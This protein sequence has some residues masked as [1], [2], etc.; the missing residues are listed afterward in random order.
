[1][2]IHDRTVPPPE[3][4]TTLADHARQRFCAQVS[5]LL[6]KITQALRD[7]LNAQ[8]EQIRAVREFQ[9]ARDTLTQISQVESAWAERVKASLI[10]ALRPVRQSPPPSSS[11]PQFEQS[12]PGFELMA[13]EAMEDQLLASKLALSIQDSAGQEWT[14]LKVRLLFA[15]GKTEMSANDVVRPETVARAVVDAWMGV[16]LT[17]DQWRMLAGPIHTA[18]SKGMA[19]TYRQTNLWL[20]AKGVMAKIKQQ[21]VVRKAVSSAPST[22]GAGTGGSTRGGSLAGSIQ[23]GLGN[24]THSVQ[25][26]AFPS[27][28]SLHSTQLPGRAGS[29]SSPGAEW[30]G[31]ARQQTQEVVGHIL[32]LLGDLTTTTTASGSQQP[33]AATPPPGPVVPS[34]ASVQPPLP[35][36]AVP[37]QP[38][39]SSSPQLQALL[40]ARQQAQYAPTVLAEDRA[41]IASPQGIEQAT[42]QLREQT[43][44]FKQAA[45]T[46]GEK[47]T[48]EIV[49]LMFQSILS[50][51]RLQ[52]SLRVWFA[53]LQIPV[54]RVALAEPDFFSSLQHPAR[55][56]IDRMGSCALGFGADLN[57]V[58]GKGLETE[59]GRIV[60]V[61][62]Q[63]PETGRKVFQL[64]L[65]EFQAFLAR[66]LQ[67]DDQTSRLVGL[68][69]QVEQKET[70][71]VQYTIELRKL[72]NDMPVR[73]DIR[74]FMF[75]IWAE[76]LAVAAVKYG[77]KHEM[78][79]NFKKVASDLLW[80][81]SAKP[82][83]NERSQVIAQLPSLLARLRKGMALLGMDL[84]TQDRH[85]KVIS[86][87]LAEAFMSRTEAIPA[88]QLT[89]LT[90]NL[91]CL[92]DFLPQ[93][94]SM[95][96]LDLD[97]E[98]IEMIT[99]I[100]ASN[101]VVITH[102]GSMANESMRTWAKELQLGSWFRLDH[103]NHVAQVQLAWRSDRGQL[104]LFITSQQQYYLMQTSRIA[105]YLQAGLLVPAEN[106]TLTVR[107]TRA[108]L[109]KLDANPERLLS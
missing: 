16:E 71:A 34:S 43:A 45:S 63:Y 88:A 58:S 78:M 24:S 19:E 86:D 100:D 36:L 99:G 35:V 85:I 17:R 79:A 90:R 28:N 27:S 96:D 76:V 37:E 77:H 20:V 40:Q 23:G 73:D 44:A 72:L 66:H 1:M 33:A 67:A 54:L 70:L 95:G 25:G 48:I 80:A 55:K 82:T 14:D 47:A 91:S 108:A 2:R 41:L 51:E 52:P 5:S 94:G 49:A 53:R 65:D 39:R 38:V 89:E 105:S 9:L 101:I 75:K 62:E 106:E 50:E 59:I 12:L 15:D 68:A 87:T 8:M 10:Q 6:P 104:S 21:H 11:T 42:N 97:Q 107:A 56:L 60:Q 29:Q 103:N 74:D 109:E 57:D 31:R 83:R 46:P 93:E 18:V 81:A 7:H 30:W 102:G 61:I 98:S 84:S 69:Q 64:A 26:S 4:L 92:E 22:A 32:R 3:P 13:T